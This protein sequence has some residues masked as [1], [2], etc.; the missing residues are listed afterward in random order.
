MRVVA[1]E[2]VSVD[3]RMEMEDPERKRDEPGGWTAP[4]WDDQLAK[5]QY[6]QL[7]A[8]DALL[9]GRETFVSFAAVWPSVTDEQGF[10]DRMNSLPKYVASRTLEEPLDWN[11]RLLEGDLADAVRRLKEEPGRDLLIYGSGQVFNTLAENQLIDEYRLMVH[12][13]ALGR[14]KPLFSDKVDRTRLTLTD[15]QTTEK[16][17]VTLIYEQ[18]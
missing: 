17:V 11:G 13:I 8:S 2:Y 12:P 18:E 5:L 7:F 1:A 4:Y 15:V 10:A 6:D 3:G 16:G 14:G 9:L